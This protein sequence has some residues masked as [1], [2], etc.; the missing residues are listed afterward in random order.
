MIK[1]LLRGIFLVAAM[2]IPC[3][4]DAQNWTTVTPSGHILNCY[5]AWV[6]DGSGN[7][8]YG[9]A[10]MIPSYT[11]GA[12][13]IPDSSV[14]M[15]EGNSTILPIVQ[16]GGE[17]ETYGTDE[18]GYV[19]DEDG[20]NL[21]A[22]TG[23]TSITIGNNVV[24][25]H[26]NAFAG[27]TGLTSITMGNS[28]QRIGQDAFNSCSSLQ[29]VSFSNAL[30]TI[31]D[32]A[33]LGC[34]SLSSITIP[35]ST[36][37][38][39]AR[40]FC[41]CSG[42]NSISLAN[43]LVDI[44]SSAF[45]G[46][47][48]LTSI[49]IPGSVTQMGTSICSGDTSLTNVVIS[50]G[51]T[52]ISSGAFGGCSSLTSVS[53]PN[54]L[55]EI[56]SGAF[57]DCSSLTSVSLPNTLMEIGAWAF[58]GCSSL[59]SVSLP[60]SITRLNAGVFSG[61]TSL[62]Q[63]VLPNSL[64]TLGYSYD[65]EYS[66]FPSHGTF[67]NCTGLTSITIPNTTSFIGPYT[68]ENCI[69][70]QNLTIPH[71]VVSINS[72]AFKGCN[73]LNL[74]APGTASIASDAFCAV[75]NVVIYLYENDNT[76]YG[77]YETWGAL[78]RDGYIENGYIYSDS[79]KTYLIKYFGEDTIVTIENQVTSIR[80]SFGSFGYCNDVGGSTIPS[81]VTTV[82]FNAEN[83]SS[84]G[85][86]PSGSA[87]PRARF[88]FG[89]RVK[90]IPACIFK[91]RQPLSVVFL[92]DSITTIGN[93]AFYGCSLEGI[94][95]PQSVRDI[96]VY[97]FGGCRG[98]GNFMLP[99]SLRQIEAGA[100][101]G[102]TDLHTLTFP[103]TVTN[104]GEQLV[105]G[106]DSLTDVYMMGNN[107]PY[108]G[109]DTPF[110]GGVNV[111]IPCNTMANYQNHYA[112]RQCNLIDT[113]SVYRTLNIVNNGGGYMQ[114][115]VGDN[116]FQDATDTVTIS[117]FDST[118]LRFRLYT[119]LPGTEAA[120]E[121]GSSSRL[122]RLLVN[123]I[124]FPI[125]SETCEI[126]DYS[127]NGGYIQY[128]VNMVVDT[129]MTIEAVYVP[130]LI[131][132]VIATASDSTLGSVTGGGTC[133]QF[134]EVVLSACANVGSTF[135]GWSNGS[136]QNPLTIEVMS[137]TTLVAY[138]TSGG[139]DS[140]LVLIHD[141]TFVNVPYAVH[142]TT[143][144]DVPY[145]VHDTT[146]IDALVHDTTTVLDT[147]TLTEYVPVHD[148][149]YIDV[150]VHDTTTVID[151]VTLTEYVPVH[152]TTYITQTDTV[153]NTVYDTITNT[154]FDTITNMVYDT[155]FVF[156]TD[157]LWLHDTVFIH[158]TICIHDTIVVGVDEVD[159]INAK[160]YTSRGQIVVDGAE[161]NTV[162]L[163]DVNGRVIATKQ[164]E[165]SPLRFDVPTSGAYM[166]KIG[167]HPARKVVVIR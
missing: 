68:F 150:Y 154:V 2:S 14:V 6:D 53:L 121:L 81:T 106:C 111:H 125:N 20:N 130:Y 28:V 147:V 141:T 136:T 84:A 135:Q 91:E 92:G 143:Y 7:Y 61:C 112:W 56:G 57:Q 41:G 128:R 107:P 63:V 131:A 132:T 142:D 8:I 43:G 58:G 23:L 152:D 137:D 55:M 24:D 126:R 124:E 89:E 47:T 144:I 12:L 162:W 119:I 166:V 105:Y 78:C 120:M 40:A 80:P 76:N 99:D 115:R 129:D 114:Y 140:V 86:G 26:Y 67:S 42:L 100:L 117:I 160:I 22:N 31:G 64:D 11:S 29:T 13:A 110:G 153:T 34:I 161:S 94:S 35:N 101:Y 21:V 148:T 70:L 46:C 118:E 25:I 93:H 73:K 164:D 15:I 19:L 1:R 146:Y 149:T 104:L 134:D 17:V 85:N 82:F 10:V 97:A 156:S 113:C 38:I 159:A 83:C 59:S 98:M 51:V 39:G 109:D 65:Y 54:T 60:N 18:N 62:T 167:N 50:G 122:M 4:A 123:G 77:D 5:D 75:L 87:F 127:N 96:G 88:V 95:I 108:T 79:S 158:D 74:L 133:Y 16:I 49:S 44:G 102:C 145:A 48:N 30:S 3:M 138:F 103:A 165:Y 116:S 66:L 90:Q 71:N 139:G 155:T 32:G 37:S 163:Y 33:F 151:T 72:N 157:T 9:L 27:F 45:A 69:G 36:I 52:I